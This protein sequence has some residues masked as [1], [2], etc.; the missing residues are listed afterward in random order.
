MHNEDSYEPYDSHKQY[1]YHFFP[2]A[3]RYFYEKALGLAMISYGDFHI[4]YEIQDKMV[5]YLELA[6]EALAKIAD[7]S[8]STKQKKMLVNA[9]VHLFYKALVDQ[10]A[11]IDAYKQGD[12]AQSAPGEAKLANTPDFGLT[13]MG[14]IDLLREDSQRVLQW[15]QKQKKAAIS[16]TSRAGRQS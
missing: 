14:N 5:F 7:D 1:P 6:R 8:L 9:D 11:I 16:V 10:K 4:D 2:E 12:A 15:S 3:G 13:Y